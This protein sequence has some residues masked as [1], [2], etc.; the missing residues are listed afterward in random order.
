MYPPMCLQCS[1]TN[2]CWNSAT[3]CTVVFGVWKQS[4]IFGCKDHVSS[5]IF[6]RFSVKDTSMYD[7]LWHC[8]HH[9]IPKQ[10]LEGTETACH[11]LHGFLETYKSWP[12][13]HASI[14]YLFVEE[15]SYLDLSILLAYNLSIG[16]SF[17]PSLSLKIRCFSKR[18]SSAFFV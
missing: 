3:L 12:V 18:S 5:S 15:K 11:K 2:V 14:L 10:K 1:P 9:Q 16:L 7:L 13:V 6:A 17:Y 8:C 4:S